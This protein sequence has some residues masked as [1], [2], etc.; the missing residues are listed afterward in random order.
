LSLLVVLALGSR[1]L[2]GDRSN[3][4][5][6]AAAADRWLLVQ[7]AGDML[8]QH[9]MFGVG[10]GNFPVVESRP[11]YDGVMVD[12]VHVIPLLVAAEAGLPAAFAWLLL[13]IGPAIARIK[14]RAYSAASVN[15]SIAISVTLLVL[16]GFDH[17]FW[18]LPP[19]RSLFWIAVGA[20]M[21]Q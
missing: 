19:G 13:V 2:V 9:P 11:P 18:T 6:G 8:R 5:G 21:T 16:S 1:L 14:W 3:P 17:Y 20:G 10:A 15:H 12:P 4:I 7:V